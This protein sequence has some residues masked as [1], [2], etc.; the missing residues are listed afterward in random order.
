V[1]TSS[2][3]AAL[4]R[5]FSTACTNFSPHFK[6]FSFMLSQAGRPAHIPKASILCDSSK[7]VI[8]VKTGIQCF[9]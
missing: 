4:A 5:I 3:P 1:V 8:P 9:L 2:L 6:P 7:V